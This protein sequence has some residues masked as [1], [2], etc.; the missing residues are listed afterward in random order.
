MHTNTAA[1]HKLTDQEDITN[2]YTADIEE[3]VPLT[4]TPVEDEKPPDGFIDSVPAHLEPYLQTKPTFG[5]DD[6]QV[7]ERRHQFGKN[8]LSEKKRNKLFHFLSFCNN[9]H[10]YSVTDI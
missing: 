9:V 3:S 7:A 10:L 8:E 6:R 4:K 1:F 5:L 2:Q